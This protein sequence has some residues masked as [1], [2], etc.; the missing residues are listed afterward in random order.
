MGDVVSNIELFFEEYKQKG[1]IPKE[2]YELML[3]TSY[4]NVI[5][6]LIC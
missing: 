3:F 1:D 6:Y 5:R 2:L 4:N